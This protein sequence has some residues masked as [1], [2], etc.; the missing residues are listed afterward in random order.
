[1]I[2]LRGAG[3][4][5]LLV[6]WTGM[7][8]IHAAPLD[9]AAERYRPYMIEGI[10][11]ALAGA[12]ALRE[13][14]AANDLV[15]ARKAWIAA[16]A[17]WERSEV[18][19]AGFVPELDAQIDA[20]PNAKSGFHAIEAKLFG[21]GRTDVESDAAA[22]VAHLDDLR[23]KLADMPLTPQGL[24]NGTVR[25]AYEVGE[26]K[27][28]G[29]ESRISGTSLDDMRNN[30]AGIDFAYRTILADALKAADARVADTVASRI[31]QLKTIVAASDLPHVDVRALRRA[32]EELVIA[33]QGA[34]TKLGLP[35]PTLE[36]QSR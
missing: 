11:D 9:E 5:A 21:A 31:E 24:L 32:S 16:R 26:S 13:R 36:A 29:G 15:G 2:D 25:L 14:A 30:V 12:R 1:M 6:V 7:C 10:G 35:R 28:D 4:V 18:F 8:A 19:T 17:G 34:S 27:A 33:L 23:G 3:C 20:W 22:L